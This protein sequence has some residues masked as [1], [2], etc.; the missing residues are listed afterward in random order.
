MP[1]FSLLRTSESDLLYLNAEW[2]KL[3]APYRAPEETKNRIFEFV[4]AHYSHPERAYHNLHH[5]A[6]LLRLLSAF[7]KKLNDYPAL[8]FAVWFHDVIYEPQRQDNEEKSAEVAGAMLGGLNAPTPIIETARQLILATKTHEAGALSTDAQFFLDADL[9]ILG[10]P[11]EI[12]AQ[13]SAAIRSE[14]SHVPDALYRQARK[15]IL[16]GF[17]NRTQ[18]YRTNDLRARFETQARENIAQELRLL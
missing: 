2:R 17:L 18:I 13:Y 9:S 4:A 10:A 12:Y 7:R 11:A 8:C 3:S 14:Y 6:E 1:D 16:Q 5:V 15:E